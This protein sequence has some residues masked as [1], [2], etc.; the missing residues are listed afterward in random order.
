MLDA[1]DISNPFEAMT[2]INWSEE[3]E[4]I[5]M[6]QVYKRLKTFRIHLL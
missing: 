6:K 3:M 2:L 4:S 1:T 5:F